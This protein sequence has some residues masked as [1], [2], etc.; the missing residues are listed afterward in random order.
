MGPWCPSYD[1]NVRVMINLGVFQAVWPLASRQ[2]APGGPRERASLWENGA[3]LFFCVIHSA[4]LLPRNSP[5]RA[6]CRTNWRV[7][8]TLLL[9]SAALGHQTLQPP[10]PDFS[11]SCTIAAKNVAPVP[12]ERSLCEPDTRGMYKRWGGSDQARL[13]VF[14]T[15]LGARRLGGFFGSQSPMM[16][17]LG[18]DEGCGLLRP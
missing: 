6:L 13:T 3:G 11:A 17:Q 1:L 4:T 5:D 12:L 14:Q 9:G 16:T 10:A 2:F 15:R 8:L 18:G 7:P